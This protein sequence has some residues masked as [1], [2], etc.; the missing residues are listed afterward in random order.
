MQEK[1]NAEKRAKLEAAQAEQE[2]RQREAAEREKAQREEAERKQAEQTEAERIERKREEALMK[3][4]REEHEQRRK[5][6]K[7][8]TATRLKSRQAAEQKA[9][10]EKAERRAHKSE[11]SEPPKHGRFGFWKNR[12]DVPEEASGPNRPRQTSNNQDMDTIRPGG[13]GA[14]LGIDAPISAVNAGDRV[15]LVPILYTLKLIIAARH[16]RVW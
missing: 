7:A 2:R 11:P 5:L 13:G 6:Q 8:E 10:I 9:K 3:L 15:S 14:V 12:R 4:D 1:L 16:G